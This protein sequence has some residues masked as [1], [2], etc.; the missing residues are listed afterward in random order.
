MSKKKAIHF[1]V[2]NHYKMWPQDST[3]WQKFRWKILLHSVVYHTRQAKAR[4]GEFFPNYRRKKRFVHQQQRWPSC[5]LEKLVW[6]EKEGQ[7][8]T[9]FMVWRFSDP[10]HHPWVT[11]KKVFQSRI[12]CQ[13]FLVVSRFPM[14]SEF[15]E[16]WSWPTGMSEEYKYG[17]CFI[18]NKASPIIFSH[19]QQ[20]NTNHLLK[21][22]KKNLHKKCYLMVIS[23]IFKKI[24][25][26]Q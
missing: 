2:W 4:G 1:I 15:D 23:S 8:K 26:Q 18:C 14:C 24:T 5:T 7:E 9:T 11:F 17:P 20:L 12:F 3:I 13:N 21:K 16:Q 19:Q 6:Y 10:F 22:R 25:N